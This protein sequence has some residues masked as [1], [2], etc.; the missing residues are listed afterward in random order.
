MTGVQ[1]R[2]AFPERQVRGHSL[3]CAKVFHLAWIVYMYQ[4]TPVVH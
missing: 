2:T 1:L 3:T 4:L